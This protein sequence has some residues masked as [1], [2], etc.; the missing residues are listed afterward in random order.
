M[1]SA[2]SVIRYGLSRAPIDSTASLTDG[3]EIGYTECGKPRWESTLHLHGMPSC[4]LLEERVVALANVRLVLPS[5]PCREQAPAALRTG[6]TPTI[7]V[8]FRCSLGEAS[9]DSPP[10]A[11]KV[12][13][14]R[15][16]LRNLLT[17]RFGQDHLPVVL[18][19]LGEPIVQGPTPT[20]DVNEHPSAI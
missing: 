19:L 12:L 20:A 9:G 1:A 11:G 2:P 13:E 8:Q 6:R 4:R 5:T 16:E 7:I 10:A 3:T 17:V 15:C 14:Q 18:D